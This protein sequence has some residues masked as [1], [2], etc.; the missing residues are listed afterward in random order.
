MNYVLQCEKCKRPA[1]VDESRT[2]HGHKIYKNIC[3]CGGKIKPCSTDIL[4][5]KEISNIGETILVS[6]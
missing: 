6:K 4:L 2:K 1:E 3:S 5:F